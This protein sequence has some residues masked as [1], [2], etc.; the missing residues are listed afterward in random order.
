MHA[1]H[2]GRL[3]R[4]ADRDFAVVT[5]ENGVGMGPVLN[6]RLYRGARGMGMALGHTKVQRN[7]ALCRRRI[8]INLPRE[9]GHWGQPDFAS[10]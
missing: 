4:H 8:A 10:N 1:G 5:I 7:G 6:K 3:C 9:R 2:Q